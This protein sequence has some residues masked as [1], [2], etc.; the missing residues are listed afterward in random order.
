MGSQ[1]KGKWAVISFDFAHPE[2]SNKITKNHISLEDL[3]CSDQD[4][5]PWSFCPSDHDNFDFHNLSKIRTVC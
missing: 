4:H 3:T 2:K 5:I 1:E